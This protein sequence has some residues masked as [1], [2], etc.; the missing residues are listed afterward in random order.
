M[1]RWVNGVSFAAGYRCASLAALDDSLQLTPA[2]EEDPRSLTLPCAPPAWTR[3]I[4]VYV[5]PTAVAV[6]GH[7]ATQSGWRLRATSTPALAAPCGTFHCPAV[8]PGVAEVRW[9]ARMN[10]RCG[11]EGVN[12]R[13]RGFCYQDLCWRAT[14]S[15]ETKSTQALALPT[16]CVITGTK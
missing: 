13:C 1:D 14:V 4:Q 5:G 12:G 15:W 7:Q 9:L 6:A 11:C 3:S 16:M 2:V 10:W 8:V